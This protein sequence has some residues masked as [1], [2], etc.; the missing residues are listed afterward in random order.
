MMTTYI[1]NFQIPGLLLIVHVVATVVTTT[2]DPAE[3]EVRNKR[4]RSH[5]D[6][7]DRSAHSHVIENQHCNI[8]RV[9]V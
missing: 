5:P 6:H 7:F 9:D 4:S 3:P 2:I 8:C 1:I